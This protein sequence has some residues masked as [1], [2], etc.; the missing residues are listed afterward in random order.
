M[1]WFTMKVSKN[2]ESNVYRFCL[3]AGHTREQLD[4]CLAAIRDVVDEL[5]LRYSR[6]PPLAHA[7]GDAE[8]P[9][10][11]ASTATF[12]LLLFLTYSFTNIYG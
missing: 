8:A 9:A 4:E 1:S 11:L 12:T 5:G 3:S 6:L 2:N 10:A 7:H